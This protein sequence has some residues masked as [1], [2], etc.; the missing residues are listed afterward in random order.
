MWCFTL[1]LCSLFWGV[2]SSPVPSTG[3]ASKKIAFVLNQ[4]QCILALIVAACT[5]LV[6]VIILVDLMIFS[7]RYRRWQ[8]QFM[9]QL[10]HLVEVQFRYRPGRYSSGPVPR[11]RS[12]ISDG[13]YI[14]STSAWLKY[15]LNDFLIKHFMISF[16]V[17]VCYCLGEEK[18]AGLD[19]M[20]SDRQ[21]LDVL[22][23]PYLERGSV[24]WV[25]Q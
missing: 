16:A 15:K 1:T 12:G 22:Y 21:N 7:R 10:T 25:L 24:G 8:T 17:S 5:F 4:S 19:Y 2:S 13:T 14:V 23:K 20:L 11:P 3:G 6:L 9:D 18:F